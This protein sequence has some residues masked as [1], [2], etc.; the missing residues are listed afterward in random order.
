LFIVIVIVHLD[1]HKAGV[2]NAQFGWINL[3]SR[4]KRSKKPTATVVTID[5]VE[6]EAIRIH[7]ESEATEARIWKE[8]KRHKHFGPYPSKTWDDIKEG[9]YKE[10]TRLLAKQKLESK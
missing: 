5:S 1:A 10:R 7:N 3:M 6:Q 2:A 4:K 9:F 8:L